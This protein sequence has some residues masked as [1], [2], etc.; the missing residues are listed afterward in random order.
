MIQ[1]SKTILYTPQ[2]MS[3]RDSTEFGMLAVALGFLTR[4]D[5]EKCI[6]LQTDMGRVGVTKRLGE[7]LLEK[8]ILSRE[9]VLL[10]LRAQG[11]RILTCSSCRKSYNVHHYKHDETYACKHCKT[12][13]ALPLRPVD[14][15]VNDSIRIAT[16]KAAKAPKSKSN[17]PKVPQ[18]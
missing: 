1:D 8:K 13:L 18:E 2:R 14:T 17:K 6:A 16:T 15:L 3:D 9:Q 4:P 5:L 7:I 10:V 12:E 11:K